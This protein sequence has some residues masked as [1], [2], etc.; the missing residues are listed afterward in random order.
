[1]TVW[2]FGAAASSG[3][4]KKNAGRMKKKTTGMQMNFILARVVRGVELKG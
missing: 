4:D 1:V 2:T 3:F